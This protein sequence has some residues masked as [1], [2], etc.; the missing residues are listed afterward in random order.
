[1]LVFHAVFLALVAGTTLF[2]ALLAA[3]NV[4][5]AADAIRERAD[6]LADRIGVEDPDELLAYHRLGTAASQLESVVVLAVVLLALYAG[7]FAGAVEFVYDAVASDLLAGVA[8]FV[9]TVLALQA[10]SLPFDAF[11]TFGVEA[12]FDFNEQSPALF[13]R[14]KLV[15]TVVAA[16]FTAVLGAA[17]L[18]TVQVFPEWWWLAATGV[19]VAFLLATQV[20]VPRVVMPLFYDFDPVED[21]SLRDAVEDVFERAGFTCDRV[22]V[23]NASSRSGHSNA[24]FTGFGAT[25]RVVLYD[26]LVEQMDDEEVQGVLAHELAHWKK[27]HIWQNVAASALQASVL[28]FV[29][30]FLLDA[31]WL[32]GMFGVPEQSAAGLLLAGLWLQ[33]LNQLTA[34]LQNKL[35]LANEREADAFAVDVMGGGDSLADA[36]ADLTSENL[37]NPFPHPY[38]EAFH[39]QHP[40]VP[41]RIRYLTEDDQA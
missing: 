32:Y 10:L 35:W 5:Y 15:G 22:Y 11:D 14:D 34:P 21:G 19:V 38:Y 24:F 23:M 13:V 40:P 33:P 30:S 41:E 7:V 18:Y 27:G 26:T 9:G 37:G 25:K 28:L 3:L 6:W 1:M 36:L 17:V 8:L 12:A 31:G 4:R 39:Y 16:V 2:F 20:L 29:A